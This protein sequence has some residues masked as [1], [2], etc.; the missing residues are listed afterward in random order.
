[1][2]TPIYFNQ[3]HRGVNRKSSTTSKIFEEKFK[4]NVDEFFPKDENR[5]FLEVSRNIIF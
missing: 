4:R 1:V 3:R 2:Q 5:K